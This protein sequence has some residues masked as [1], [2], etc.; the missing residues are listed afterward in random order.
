MCDGGG[1]GKVKKISILCHN[2]RGRGE[3]AGAGDQIR[4]LE[5]A[6]T[7]AA[8]TTAGK[9]TLTRRRKGGFVF[10]PCWRSRK[11]TRFSTHTCLTKKTTAHKK[12]VHIN[13]ER[14]FRVEAHG[15]KKGCFFWE[16]GKS[17]WA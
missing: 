4:G 16:S 17:F 5:G 13:V 7:A 12:V 8:T 14:N 6:I 11:K 9:G 2:Y 15:Y 3:S 10:M 1:G